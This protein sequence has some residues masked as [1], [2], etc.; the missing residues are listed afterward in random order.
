M[1]HQNIRR[2]KV[3]DLRRVDTIEM[4]GRLFELHQQQVLDSRYCGIGQSG[5]TV[6]VAV[7]LVFYID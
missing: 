7:F 4:A 6:G 5:R 3:S 1:L 2:V